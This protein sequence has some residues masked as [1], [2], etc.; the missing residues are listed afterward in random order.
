V[1]VAATAVVQGY[2]TVSVAV[3]AVPLVSAVPVVSSVV[4]APTAVT[5][6]PVALSNVGVC[7]VGGV[8]VQASGLNFGG[9]GL[10]VMPVV[11]PRLRL[12]RPAVRSTARV[13]VR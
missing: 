13:V 12:F 7:A 3:A 11:R 5:V 1:E 8:Q 9:V 10:G 4:V 2:P 6:S